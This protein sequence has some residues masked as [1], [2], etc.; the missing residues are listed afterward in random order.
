[1][2]QVFQCERC[3][4]AYD[5]AG[6]AKRCEDEHAKRK[7]AAVLSQLYWKPKE[8]GRYVERIYPDRVQVRFGE[9]FDFG[10]YQL[11]Q[12]GPRGC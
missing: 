7:E 11:V 12:V 8:S 6:P 3:G 10:I 4:A 1:M 2:K 5:D 9:G